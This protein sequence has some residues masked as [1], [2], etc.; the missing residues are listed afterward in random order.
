MTRSLML[1][2]LAAL[3]A[4]AHDIAQ[5]HSHGLQELVA[6]HPV[7]GRVAVWLSSGL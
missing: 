3:P 1:V 7:D 4:F 5:S 2:L 6:E